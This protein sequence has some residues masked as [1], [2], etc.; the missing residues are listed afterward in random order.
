M[1]AYC[2]LYGDYKNL[3]NLIKSKCK[4]NYIVAK[5]KKK[6]KKTKF[7]TGFPLTVQQDK[8]VLYVS[9]PTGKRLLGRPRCRWE[10]NIRMYLK[11]QVSI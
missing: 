2:T 3:G 6:E 10:D 8:R 4:N 7:K 5:L 1:Q 11:K 9:F